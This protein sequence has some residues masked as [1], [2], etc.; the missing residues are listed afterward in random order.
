M[1]KQRRPP[2]RPSPRKTVK[3][4]KAAPQARPTRTVP[5]PPP[6]PRP[7][8]AEAVALYEHGLEALQRHDYKGAAS[9]LRRVLD[10]FPEE[11]E[12]TERA[13]LYLKVCERQ[14]QPVTSTP[15][16]LEERVYAATI[17]LNSG[18]YQEAVDLLRT[19]DTQDPANDAAQYMLAVAHTL[20]GDPDAGL[21]HLRKA[22]ELNPENRAL[23]R[24][25]P[26]LE[27]IRNI[28]GFRLLLEA[29]SS[30]RRPRRI[31]R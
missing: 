23:A 3:V 26:D 14:L 7:R 22:I 2:A 20:K 16:T 18:A 29:G 17:A 24:Q 12:L 5:P 11:R 9:A 15:K 8:Y 28:D 6:A 1:A 27:P 19:V 4:R 10:G 30:R 25:D 21:V 13:R 31:A